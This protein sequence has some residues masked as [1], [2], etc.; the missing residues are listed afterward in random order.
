MKWGKD[1]LLYLFI[2]FFFQRCQGYQLK[3]MGRGVWR[4]ETCRFSW[5]YQ[6]DNKNNW[7]NGN[8]IFLMGVGAALMITLFSFLEDLVVYFSLFRGIFF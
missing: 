7:N 3:K 8:L 6:K 5:R 4:I 2:F 1:L